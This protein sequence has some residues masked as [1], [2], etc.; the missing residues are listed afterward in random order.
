M[1]RSRPRRTGA[2]AVE[3]AVVLLVLFVLVFGILVGGVG[4]FR[5]QQVAGLARE[6]A[7]WASVRGGQY[8]KET[9]QAPPTKQQI[10]DAA[11]RPLAVGMD[12]AAVAV[13][14]EWVDKGT[15]TAT[16]WDAAPKDV[17]SV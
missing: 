5:H 11:V 10:A 13:Q 1:T 9:G 6:G 12:P 14:V 17:W 4:V 16:D 3:T 8:Y 2:T 7:R 15:N